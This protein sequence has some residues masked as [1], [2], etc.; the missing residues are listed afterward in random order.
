MARTISF[1]DLRDS[2]LVVAAVYSG[3]SSKNASDDPVAQLL[4]VGN[5]GGIRFRGSRVAPLMVVLV[6][7]G[8][9]LDWPDRLE[10]ETGVFTYYGDNKTPGQEL[11]ETRRGGNVVLR[12]LF[13]A[14]HGGT[15]GRQ[16][17]CPIFAF[18]GTGSGRDHTF[19]G[20][21]VPGSAGTTELDDLTG[22][23]RSS[24]GQRYQNYRASFTV[25]DT[26]SVTRGWIDDIL[27][28]NPESTLAPRT[29][30]LWRQ[31]GP[32]RALTAPR[33]TDYR[34]RVDQEP[35]GA[36]DRN[37]LDLIHAHFSD[38]PHDFEQFAADIVRMHLPS[39]TALDVTRRS[40][41]GGR[42]AIGLYQVGAGAGG[43]ELD[44]SVEAKCY[45]RGNSVGVRE[46][47]RLISRLRHRQFGVLVT[48]SH[49]D[50]QAYKELKEDRHPIVVIAGRDIVDALKR[51][52]MPTGAK[53]SD[54]LTSSYPDPQARPFRR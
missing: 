41:D 21:V 44:F 5:S 51:A 17:A 10:A 7:S 25:L 33:T 9:D 4:P 23:W 2:D 11:H 52:G 26:A 36:P 14:A 32:P 22:V 46:L 50:L 8:K 31:G 27:Q 43:I 42:D 40:R 30:L 16:R 24:A 49:L 35:A 12:N 15:N 29:W 13:D 48:T 6:T 28:G 20:L 54:W 3:G 1:A 34:S 19:L 18:S 47:S 38:R 39:V 45:R 37:A 53:L